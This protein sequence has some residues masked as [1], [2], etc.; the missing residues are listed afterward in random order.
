VIPTLKLAR[1]LDR[2]DILG[3]FDHAQDREIATRITADAALILFGDIS[4]DSAEAHF[5]LHL[6]QG[7]NEALHVDGIRSQDVEGNALRALGPDTG[8][9]AELIDQVL[10]YAFVHH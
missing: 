1:L 3:L 10:N 4:A 8:K 2:D 5:L 9:P 6:A 7:V